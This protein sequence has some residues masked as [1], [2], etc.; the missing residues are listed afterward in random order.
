M[1]GFGPLA[2]LPLAGL[3]VDADGN[4]VGV[5]YTNVSTFGTGIIGRGAVNITGALYTDADTFGAHT[6][7]A[8]YTVTG[9]LYSDPD[10]FGAAT[11][12]V[13]PVTITGL[14]YADPDTFGTHTL[15]PGPVTIHAKWHL[16]TD[17]FWTATVFTPTIEYVSP[18]EERCMRCGF[19]YPRSRLRKEWTGLLVCESTCWDPKHPQMALRGV[20]DRQNLPWTRPEPE[21]VFVEPAE[22]S[23]DD[24]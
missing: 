10:A 4:I 19:V 14:L 20:P 2:D 15:S 3:P 11:L 16:D 1:L 5:L 22:Q 18:G 21:P 17:T 12:T 8:S 13:G 23:G 9:A 7:S 24:L 6:V